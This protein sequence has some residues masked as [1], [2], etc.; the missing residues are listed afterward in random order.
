MQKEEKGK[1]DQI[2]LHSSESKW[3]IND[4]MDKQ[5]PIVSFKQRLRELLWQGSSGCHVLWAPSTVESREG[6]F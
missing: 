6:G 2:L 4:T 1:Q 3:R 5:V